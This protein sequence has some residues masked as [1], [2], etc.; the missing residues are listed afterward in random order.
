MDCA[1]DDE[2][3]LLSLTLLQLLRKRPRQTGVYRKLVNRVVALTVETN[4]LTGMYLD[5]TAYDMTSDP[6]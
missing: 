1:R 4:S 5:L 2:S 6:T 3:T